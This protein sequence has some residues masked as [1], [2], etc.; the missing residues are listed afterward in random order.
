MTGK[1]RF[2]LSVMGI[3]TLFLFIPIQFLVTA[4]ET[5]AQSLF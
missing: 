1:T 5:A 2:V 4:A 3:I